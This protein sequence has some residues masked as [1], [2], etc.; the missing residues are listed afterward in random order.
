MFDTGR[1]QHEKVSHRGDV[2]VGRLFNGRYA[3]FKT[4]FLVNNLTRVEVDEKYQ[5]IEIEY[6]DGSI[7]RP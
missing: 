2:G 4:N 5:I 6:A 3:A 7:S 1:F